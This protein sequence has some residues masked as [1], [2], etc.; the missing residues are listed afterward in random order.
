[1]CSNEFLSTEVIMKCTTAVEINWSDVKAV[2]FKRTELL[3]I[4]L[5]YYSQHIEEIAPLYAVKYGQIFAYK[6]KNEI[7][8]SKAKHDDLIGKTS[9]YVPPD[10]GMIIFSMMII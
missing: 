9:K 4:S 2:I 10:D 8:I 1:M 7:A 3:N 5:E 6:N